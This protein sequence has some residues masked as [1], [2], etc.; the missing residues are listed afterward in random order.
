[1]LSLKKFQ[2]E[3]VRAPA[4]SMSAGSE[5]VL[6]NLAQRTS[7]VGLGAE[8]SEE[9]LRAAREALRKVAHAASDAVSTY[10]R[11]HAGAAIEDAARVAALGLA[12][13]SAQLA[14]LETPRADELSVLRDARHKVYLSIM[15][16]RQTRARVDS[17]HPPLWSALV[18]SRGARAALA[19]VRAAFPG[20]SGGEH[21]EDAFQ[22][23]VVASE[24]ES[25]RCQPCFGDLSSSAARRL[26]ELAATLSAP[27]TLSESP[28]E[29]LCRSRQML[30]DAIT[31][32]GCASEQRFG[33][34]QM[35]ETLV[36]ELS[37][38]R[39]DGKL[40]DR[41]AATLRALRGLDRDLDELGMLLEDGACPPW[42]LLLQRATDL[43]AQHFRANR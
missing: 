15:T 5:H 6:E 4:A 19:S 29:R 18:P 36:H 11:D 37:E 40:H 42:A 1:M 24:F 10:A 23:F 26:S 38:R 32:L 25:V 34:E 28:H 9:G 13:A 27:V 3:P 7:Q 21:V 31:E 43:L 8:L 41:V 22:L 39:S 16:L 35:L 30:D 20:A 33:D 12:E 2:P 17:V 14:S